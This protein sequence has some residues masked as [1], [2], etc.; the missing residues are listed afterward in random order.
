[1]TANEL[2]QRADETR[3][4]RETLFE[5]GETGSILDY[6]LA[7]ERHLRELAQGVTLCEES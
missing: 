4:R 6:L 1:M 2:L 7:K 5:E 3:L